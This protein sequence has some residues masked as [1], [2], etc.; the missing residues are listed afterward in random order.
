MLKRLL[1]RSA[2]WTE[3]FH[4]S[5]CRRHLVMTHWIYSVCSSTPTN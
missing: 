4:I 5:V 2:V 1:D 3:R